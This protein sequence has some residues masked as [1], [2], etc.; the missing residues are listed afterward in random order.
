MDVKLI[1]GR[2]ILGL[3]RRLLQTLYRSPVRGKVLQIFLAVNDPERWKGAIEEAKEH[4]ERER[5]PTLVDVMDQKN[6]L[7]VVAE[8]FGVP[9]KDI[10]VDTSSNALTV[11]AKTTNGKYHKEVKLPTPIKTETAEITYKK[12]VLEVKL[13]KAR[14]TPI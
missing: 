7:I 2:F 14:E 5:C 12:G 8:M 9:E 6:H 1:K 11:I 13:E 10:K 3:K 4:R